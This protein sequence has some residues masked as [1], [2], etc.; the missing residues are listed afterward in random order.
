MGHGVCGYPQILQRQPSLIVQLLEGMDDAR[1]HLQVCTML[2][3]DGR[4]ASARCFE[5][6]QLFLHFCGAFLLEGREFVQSDVLEVHTID[7]LLA[8]VF[9]DQIVCERIVDAIHPPAK[10]S[11]QIVLP[12]VGDLR[13]GTHLSFV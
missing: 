5:R 11:V 7:H 9:V 3:A 13:H 1:M 10:L 2:S 4:I 12:I 6:R 8:L